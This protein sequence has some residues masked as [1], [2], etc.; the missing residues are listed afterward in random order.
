MPKMFTS[1]NIEF[2]DETNS[3]APNFYYYIRLY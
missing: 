1:K 3:G 2:S